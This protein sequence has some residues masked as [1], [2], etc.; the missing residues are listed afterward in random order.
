MEKTITGKTSM[1]RMTWLRSF[2]LPAV[3]ACTLA[4]PAFA[5]STDQGGQPRT[6]KAKVWQIPR[7]TRSGAAVVSNG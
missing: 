6:R 5:Q 1:K 7:P 4:M 3:M 2:A